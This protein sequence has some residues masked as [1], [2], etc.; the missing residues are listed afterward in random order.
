MR[1]YTNLVWVAGGF[2]RGQMGR[3][4][5]ATIQDGYRRDLIRLDQ[6]IYMEE[7]TFLLDH[8]LSVRREAM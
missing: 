8:R 5:W 4:N 7:V 1:N 2:R 3:R 6:R